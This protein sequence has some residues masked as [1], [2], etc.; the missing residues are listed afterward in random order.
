MKFGFIDYEMSWQVFSQ[1]HT[2]KME[3]NTFLGMFPCCTDLDG[4][5][6]AWLNSQRALGH[7][8]KR[9]DSEPSVPKEAKH[10]QTDPV[11]D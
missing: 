8:H 3:T 10:K 5:N 7:L 11:S 4:S 9:C 2:E 6:H 1:K